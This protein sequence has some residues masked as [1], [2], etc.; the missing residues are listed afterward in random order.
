MSSFGD[1]FGS[2]IDSAFLGTDESRV[3]M[4]RAASM[5][6][7]DH[8]MGVGANHF[9]L[10]A[11]AQGYFARSG[12]SWIGFA[13]T[14]H[15]AYWLVAAETG[16]IGI[17]AFVILLL[18]PLTVAFLCGWR[19]RGDR[20]GDLLLGLGVALLMVYLHSFYEWV[21]V[22]FGVQYIF[23]V[24]I[25]LVAGLAQQLGY[26]SRSRTHAVKFASEDLVGPTTKAAQNFR[27]NSLR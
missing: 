17:V 23:A 8:P 3:Q 16:Y 7:S 5:M 15:N 9:V 4:A 26:W 27:I 22:T 19:N 12:L 13:S 18:R 25:G 14:V 10:V 6:L 24:T 21:F 2:D 11:N 20:R 1:R